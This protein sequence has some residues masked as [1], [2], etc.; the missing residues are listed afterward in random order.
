M[1]TN[2]ACLHVHDMAVHALS[3][4]HWVDIRD[5]NFPGLGQSETPGTIKSESRDSREIP[6]L[7][8]L[9]NSRHTK[10]GFFFQVVNFVTVFVAIIAT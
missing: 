10:S 7:D 6:K 5:P 4:L 1:T 9:L 3:A 2:I 8:N